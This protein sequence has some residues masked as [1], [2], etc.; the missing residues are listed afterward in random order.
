M[1]QAPS[2]ATLRQRLDAQGSAWFELVDQINE[3]L[4]ALRLDGRP[5]DF[6]LLANGYCPV[7]I[8]TFAMDNGDSAKEGVGRTYAGVDGYCPL[9]AYLGTQGYC[10]QLALR[11]GTQH[12]A[13][14]S[15]YNLEHVLPLAARLSSAPLLL[16]ADSGFCSKDLMLAV[17][18]H[19][20]ALGR[21]VDYLIKWN[22]RS[23]PVE[24][25]AQ[26]KC[27]D[28]A[29]VWCLLREGK[30]ACVWQAD[31]ELARGEDDQPIM[32][33]R[34]YRLTE[35]TID[36]QGNPLLL[37]QYT[38]EGWS[39]S[40]PQSITPAQIIGLYCQHGT[41]EPFHSGFK[42]DMGQ[43]GALTSDCEPSRQHQPPRAAIAAGAALH[44]ACRTLF[45]ECPGG[46][47]GDVHARHNGQR[48][49]LDAYRQAIRATK[50]RKSSEAWIRYG[51]VT[52]S[53]I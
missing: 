6:G 27:A 46:R 19:A 7:D 40:L 16:R 33:R 44:A 31:V 18:S 47:C 52:D 26:A 28:E 25:W 20:S 1:R 32:A 49:V 53:G 4:L 51:V 10:L 14:E 48:R 8:D 12:S 38:L 23:T 2:C 17:H 45:V 11:P 43:H 29:T 21:T 36:K 39:T 41:H 15:Q 5:I 9:A 35:R 50:F 24:A 13:C 3:Q 34:I 42:T 22:P 30:R 37:P